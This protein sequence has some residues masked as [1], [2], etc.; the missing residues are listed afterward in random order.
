MV[1]NLN[2]ASG[3]VLLVILVLSGCDSVVPTDSVANNTASEHTSAQ[4]IAQRTSS[5]V[6]TN[7]QG[8]DFFIPGCT[9]RFTVTP[10]GAT[11]TWIVPNGSALISSGFLPN[12]DAYGDY[13]LSNHQKIGIH[14][15][16]GANVIGKLVYRTS[17]TCLDEA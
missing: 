14:Y 13:A 12:G 6:P 2:R 17:G 16:Y 9:V 4:N 7:F 1:S 10:N 3:F 11:G 5:N 8:P 15:N